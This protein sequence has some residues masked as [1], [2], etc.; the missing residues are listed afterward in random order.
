MKSIPDELLV[1]TICMISMA[2]TTSPWFSLI[3]RGFGGGT[4]GPAN[5]WIVG[6]RDE[7]GYF[8]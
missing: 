8:Q 3:M 2:F 5:V 4:V 7:R 1:H 6:T